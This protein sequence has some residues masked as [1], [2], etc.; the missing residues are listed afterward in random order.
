MKEGM[1]IHFTAAFKLHVVREVELG[2]ITK[3]GV[4][5]ERGLKKGVYLKNI[6]Y[7]SIIL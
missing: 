4:S 6:L 1:R 7:T 5:P 3:S 2:R